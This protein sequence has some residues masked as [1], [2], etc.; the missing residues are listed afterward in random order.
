MTKKKRNIL[1]IASTLVVAITSAFIFGGRVINDNTYTVESGEFENVIS[2]KGEMK[3]QVYTKIN[4]PEVMTNPDLNIYHL[5]I[6]DLVDEGTIVK[7]GDYV[8]LLDQERIKG[9]L[10]RT[11]ERLEN[12]T[13]E[14]NMRQIDSTSNL[15]NERNNIQ[16]LKYDL[17]YKKLEIKQSIYESKSYQEKIKRE[18]SRA[19]RKLEMSERDYKRSSMWHSSRC[20]Y[21]KRR[22]DDI[23]ERKATLEQAVQEARI[24]APQD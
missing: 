10:N 17:E 12:Y 11:N 15:T 8:A 16:E 21:S 18:Y 13:N 6:N 14:L 9:E 19:L 20:N 4:M 24:T 23:T 5:M 7:Q 22:L 1:I 2:C 3:S